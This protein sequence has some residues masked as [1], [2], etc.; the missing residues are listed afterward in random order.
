MAET[1][2]AE[3]IE[4]IKARIAQAAARAGREADEVTLIAVSKTIPALRVAEAVEAGMRRF[5]ESYVQEA[6]AKVTD[7]LLQ[8]S[9]MEWHFIGHLQSNKARDVVRHFDLIHSVDSL[10]LA[11]EIGRRAQQE[12]RTMPI[13]LEVKLDPAPAKFGFAPDQ[14]L[15]EAAQTA[16]IPGV[17]LRGLMGMAPFTDRPE[18]TRPAFKRLRALFDRLPAHARYT[19]SMGMTGDFEVAIEEGATH[20]RIGTAIF[21]KR[22]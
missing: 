1:E 21:G 17:E 22:E 10:A 8:R 20:V 12:G 19:L 9:D 5:G 3:N 6:V 18:E 7:P 4:R 11:R 16:E 2:I 13:L 14:V 15:D